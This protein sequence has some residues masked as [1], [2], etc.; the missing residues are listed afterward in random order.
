[1][2][3]LIFLLL[4]FVSAVM[5]AQADNRDPLIKDCP[6]IEDCLEILGRALPVEDKGIYDHDVDEIRAILKQRFGDAARDALLEKAQEG[7]GGWINFAGALLGDWGDWRE[8]HLPALVAALRKNSGGWIARAL[9]ELG[10]DGAIRALVDD[11]KNGDNNQTSFALEQLG[12]RVLPYLLPLL[13]LPDPEDLP[14]DTPYQGGWLTAASVIKANKSNSLSIADEW[15]N[16]ASNRRKIAV[17]RIAALRGLSAIGGYLGEKSVRLRPLLR[18][19][20]KAISEQTYKTLVAAFDS[21][22]ARRLAA[23]CEPVADEWT[24]IDIES[25]LCLRAL[26]EFGTNARQAGDLVMPYLS[27]EKADQLIGIETL[28]LIGYEPAIPKI[29]KFLES[30]DWRLVLAATRALGQ[31]KAYDLIP[32]IEKATRDHWLYE[33]QEYAGETVSA[34]IR[35]RQTP[36]PHNLARILSYYGHFGDPLW[37]FEPR[38]ECGWGVWDYGGE[39]LTFDVSDEQD[40]QTIVLSDG[41]LVATDEGEFGGAL[42]WRGRDGAEMTIVPD[43]TSRLLPAGNGFIAL[44]G[45]S[46]LSINYGFATLV[47]RDGDGWKAKEIARFPGVAHRAKKLNDGLFVAEALGHAVI[48]NETGIIDQAECDWSARPASYDPY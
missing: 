45:I 21:S 41:S 7:H 28:G 16:L 5:P 25:L 37:I 29:E 2:R 23:S 42:V 34:L 36:E 3:F 19:R 31:L 17:Q 33:I 11:L 35:R 9:G 18:D 30:S 1:M 13:E 40:G 43:N 26:S 20:D 46:H 22:V 15:V 32:K 12:P 8:E 4:L 14:P 39:R 10:T 24:Y 48:F 47:M 38:G 6:S 27:A 44:H